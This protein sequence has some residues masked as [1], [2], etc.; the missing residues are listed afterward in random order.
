MSFFTRLSIEDV[1]APAT[2]SAMRRTLGPVS[3]TMIGV[4]NAI[5]A[6]VFILT[7][8]AAAEYA[9]P[10]VALSFVIAA[11]VCL[12]TALCYGELGA[13][14][15]EA[16]G[17]YIYARVALG[18]GPALIVGWCMILEYLLAASTV[19][20]GWSGYAVQLLLTLGIRLPD[21]LTTAPF[22]GTHA[23][24]SINLPAVLLIV[25]CTFILT[26]GTRFSVGL[27]A[28]MVSLKVIIIMLVILAGWR[29][30]DARNWTPFL[31]P[32]DLVSH[33]YGL[34]G[35]FTASAYAFFSYSGFEAL[36]TSAGEA[37]NPS[38]D[39]PRS[40]LAAIAAC[41]VLY[42]GMSLLM[43]GL[44]PYHKLD[45]A[46]PVVV[47]LRGA[48]G[49]L[50]WLLPI[51]EIGTVVG[52][53][54]VA[55][56]SLYGQ[57][58]VFMSMARAGDLPKIFSKIDPVARVPVAGSWIVG[59]L[60]AILAGFMPL[61]LLAELVSLGCLLAFASVCA[62]VFVLRRTMPKIARPFRVPFGSF[63]PVFGVV[64]CIGLM[65]SLPPTTWTAFVTWLCIGA[66][67]LA[68]KQR[69]GVAQS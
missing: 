6:G 2:R 17:S 3:L 36:S 32:A 12:A 66:V 24:A 43:T 30:T 28:A 48:H 62:S 7:G 38:R 44:V 34:R 55:L 25:G 40:L 33:R 51:V 39:L 23:L 50:D 56:V 1:V 27:N 5:G 19:A 49:H 61:Q 69:K 42:V 9:G 20:V 31:P 29:F 14:M 60:A 16:G 59:I 65:F 63:V 64:T 35:L 22:A 26:R 10:A 57:V 53:A 45:V 58:R 4:S 13:L 8:T 67:A 41:T 47:A 68:I 15:P 21:R 37:R 52:L 11:L 18:H 46:Y 54:S